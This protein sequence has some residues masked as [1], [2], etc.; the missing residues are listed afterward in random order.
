MSEQTKYVV[1]VSGGVDSV[2]LLDMLIRKWHSDA[3]GTSAERELQG[4]APPFVIAHFDHG[5][6]ED[7]AIDAEFVRDLAEKYSLPFEMRREELGANASEEL[8]R[9]RRYAFLREVARK[10]NAKIM[11][12]HHA[13]DTVE[14]IAIN[15]T[16]G[17]G[18][19]GLAVLD[20]PDIV[21]PLLDMTKKEIMTYAKEHK[22]E[23]RED[24]TNDDTKYLR[25]KLR[26]KLAALDDETKELLRLYRDRQVFLRRDVDNETGK[27][28]GASPY[29]R[30]L[31]INAPET[32]A[33]ELLRAVL[34]RDMGSSPTRPQLERALLA[35]K[36]FRAGKRFEVTE[37]II[38]QFTRTHFV[39]AHR[40]KVL[41]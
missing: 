17:T 14:T 4:Q 37:D 39:V 16:R 1:A 24:A 12:A 41:S 9:D 21:R 8:A 32:A 22:L 6:R 23:W 40:D 25:N 5:I 11:T 38:L 30:Y 10:H 31:Y 2:A 19:R 3:E 33:L 28:I 7:S 34:T 36:T 20:S 13:D 18:W 26:Q 35:I 27:L 29:A 15:L